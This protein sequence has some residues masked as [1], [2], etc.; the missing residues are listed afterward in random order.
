[1][2]TIID[3]EAVRRHKLTSQSPADGSVFSP[4]SVGVLDDPDEGGLVMYY[5][6]FNL[7]AKDTEGIRFGFNY[8]EFGEDGWPTL[9]AERSG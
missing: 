8:L 3:D 6:Y 2:F 4:G 7:S 9:V 1:M 5:Q